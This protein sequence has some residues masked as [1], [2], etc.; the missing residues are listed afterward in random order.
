MVFSPTSTASLLIYPAPVGNWTNYTEYDP[1]GV[2]SYNTSIYPDGITKISAPWVAGGYGELSQNISNF[3]Q[4]DVSILW[5]G[6]GALSAYRSFILIDDVPVCSIIVDGIAQTYCNTTFPAGNFKLSIKLNST[7]DSW[8]DYKFNVRILSYTLFGG[9]TKPNLYTP[10]NST[11]VFKDYPPLTKTISFTWALS[12]ENSNLIIAKDS[13]F[14]IIVV[15]TITSNNYSTQ[16]LEAGNY[17][18]KVRY[19]NSTSETY[20]NYSD[21]FN[22]TLTNNV[23]ATGTGIHGVVYELNGAQTPLSG[24]TVYIRKETLNWSDRTITGSNG[25]YLFDNLTNNTIYSIYAKAEGYEDGVT[26]YVTTIPG[27]RITKNIQLNKCIS[28]FNC[29]YN[30]HYVEFTVQNLWFTKYAGVTATA[31][32]GSELTVSD[33]KITGTDGSVNLLLI[34]D[35]QYRIT[36][37]NTTQGISTS[38]VGYPSKTDYIIITDATSTSGWSTHGTDAA[39]TTQIEVTTQT[40]N[41][42]HAYV[43]V[44]YND[45]LAG[46]SNLIFYL[47]KTI[48]G[49]PNNQTVLQTIDGGN[50]DQYNASFIV[51]GYG[52]NSYLVKVKADHSTYG[53]ISYSYAVQFAQLPGPLGNFDP[54]IILMLFVGFI[55]FVAGMFGQTMSEQGSAILVGFVWILAGIGVFSAANIGLNFYLGLTLATVIVIIMNINAR[56]R[57]EGLQ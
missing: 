21:T 16:S 32:K 33:T 25:Y 42:T 3:T 55:L 27:Q 53:T 48:A 46:T 2:V 23:S 9:T 14:D 38:W 4:Q 11:T 7:D 35:Q 52:G 5:E 51:S 39:T 43:N 28:G 18:W 49:D 36:F 6:F 19:Y 24:A 1:G 50:N 41:D 56:G 22:F 57:Q 20:S 31:Y 44:S 30:Q 12:L 45:T 40:I 26:E 10:I 29:F 34:K 8:F 17:W 37:I 15:D 13:N 47:N 54:T